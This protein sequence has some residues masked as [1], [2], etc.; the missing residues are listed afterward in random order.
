MKVCVSTYSFNK[1]I[2]SGSMT[3]CDCIKKAAEMGFDS[4]EISELLAGEGQDRTEYAALL[5]KTADEAGIA[6]TNFNFGA[7][8]ITGSDGNFDAEVE[9]VCGMVDMAAILDAG[10]VR[11][12]AARNAGDYRCFARA[13]PVIAEGCRRVT[14]YAAERGIKTMVE[15]HGF[16]AQDSDRVEALYAAVGHPNFSLLTDIGN[17]TCADENPINAVSRVAPLAGFVHIKD[18]HIK[19]GAEPDPGKGFFKSRGGNYLRGAVT[20]QGN[21]PVKQCLDIL[22]AAGYDGYVSIEFEGVEDPL[23]ALPTCL[24]NARRYI[25]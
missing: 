4:V 18:F 12:D 19:S 15:N 9:R 1:R 11:H 8:F 5:K 7:D 21:V 16:F 2:A 17:F 10:S 25:D 22:K 23:D 3:Q 24:E 6:I 20:G 13:L 14:E